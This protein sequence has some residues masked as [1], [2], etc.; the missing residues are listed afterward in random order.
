MYCK[1]YALVNF[2]KEDTHISGE[3]YQIS[4]EGM[5]SLDV[6]KK[7]LDDGKYKRHEEEILMTEDSEG[8]PFLGD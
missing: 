5:A 8:K 1:L 6:F 2:D 4:E 7:N 3:I